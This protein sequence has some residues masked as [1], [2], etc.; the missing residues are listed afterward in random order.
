MSSLG[1]FLDP[2]SQREIGL[3][4]FIVMPRFLAIYRFFF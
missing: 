2:Q 4:H 3:L 1:Y